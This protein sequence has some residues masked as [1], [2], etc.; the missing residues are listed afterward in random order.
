[1]CVAQSLGAL[2]R[3]CHLHVPQFGDGD[4]EMLQCSSPPGIISVFE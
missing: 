4:V 1:M 2:K 3:R